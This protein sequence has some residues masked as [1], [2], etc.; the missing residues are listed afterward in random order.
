ML[1]RRFL[2]TGAA[3]LMGISGAAR[4]ARAMTGMAESQ[5]AIPPTAAAGR[6]TPASWFPETAS[7]EEFR[8]LALVAMQ[9]AQQAGADYADIRIGV[10]R[11]FGLGRAQIG[12]GYGVRARVAGSWC[13]QHG[14]ILTSD[15]IASAARTAV[16]GARA[17]A[18]LNVLL[19][20]TAVTELAPA[21]VVT[22]E[23]RSPVEID[24]FSVPID[25]YRLLTNTFAEPV[26]SLG[27]VNS[28]GTLSWMVET[29]VFA[30]TAGSLVTQELTRGGAGIFV[31]ARLPENESDDVTLRVPG[32]ELRSAGFETAVRSDDFPSRIRATAEEAIRWRALP[33]RSFQDVGRHAV[34]CDGAAFAKLIG[35]TVIMALDGD[36]IGG[37]EADASG[38][39][40][41]TPVSDIVGAATPL[42]SPLLTIG[43]HRAVPSPTAVRWD[44]EG[45]APEP[46]SLIEKG[47]VVDYH[48][49]RETAPLLADWYRQRGRQLR[50]HGTA[51]APTPASLPMGGGGDVSIAPSTERATIE[52]LTRG[53][54]RGFLVLGGSVDASPGLTRALLQPDIVI[55]IQRGQPVARVPNLWF[56]FE[57]NAVANR[58]LSAL[59]DARTLGTAT[60]I[61]AK[62]MPW[63]SMVH[64]VR[65]P[66]ALLKD[67]AVIRTDQR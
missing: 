52:D 8:A 11:S 38:P 66:A 37:L 35:Q 24:P 67:I 34:V 5:R 42:F 26:K 28:S 19:G 60:A 40:F 63:E 4:A 64:P 49:T 31:N 7:A 32:L 55:E 12:V 48:T 2:T 25:E 22:G 17:S 10:Q 1:R 6:T 27:F 13:F 50:S 16:T 44:D 57:T 46:V 20:N 3:T 58:S 36:R 43:S 39:S 29:R 14:N 53:M 51:V 47:R 33:L 18:K 21:P 59:G 62:G 45:V 15:A 41:L 23:W 56:S 65:A 9:A 61:T 30:S 54:A